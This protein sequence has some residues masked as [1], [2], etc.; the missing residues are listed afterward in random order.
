MDTTSQVEEYLEICNARQ[1]Q[2]FSNFQ[3]SF[4]C[5]L[6]SNLAVIEILGSGRFH[7]FFEGDVRRE[8]LH[9]TRSVFL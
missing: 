3:R 2:R 1:L 4:D 7:I 9:K 8:L 5:R 6:V